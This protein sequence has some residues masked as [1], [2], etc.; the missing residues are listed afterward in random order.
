MNPF[1]QLLM[2]S[3]KSQIPISK[4]QE[5]KN[6]YS[7]GTWR[8]GLGL[9]GLVICGFGFGFL[10]LIPGPLSAQP[11]PL[12]QNTVTVQGRQPCDGCEEVKRAIKKHKNEMQNRQSRTGLLV[13]I[14]KKWI[15]R[16]GMMRTLM[17]KNN[18][19]RN[20]LY[21]KR[22]IYLACENGFS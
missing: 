6:G 12:E 20:S 18:H 7:L 10:G 17:K 9:L 1:Q 19:N 22:D 16:G 2:K 3:P 21:K 8:L 14:G 13:K 11:L 5:I 15:R 4:S